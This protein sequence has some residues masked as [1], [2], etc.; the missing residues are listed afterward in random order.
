MRGDKKA[1]ILPLV[2]SAT[3]DTIP[4]IQ[5]SYASPP[6]DDRRGKEV[7]TALRLPRLVQRATRDVRR[8]GTALMKEQ[9]RRR[10]PAG[11]C[12]PYHI[13]Q[14]NSGRRNAGTGSQGIG[15]LYKL[16]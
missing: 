9:A 8:R 15:I 5:L 10:L 14:L 11:R 16:R 13:A 2:K 6:L 7:V 3:S 4:L 12:A 1:L